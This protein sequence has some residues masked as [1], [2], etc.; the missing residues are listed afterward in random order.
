MGVVEMPKVVSLQELVRKLDGE[1]DRV[2]LFEKVCRNEDAQLDTNLSLASMVPTR[3]NRPTSPRKSSALI[4]CVQSAL[5]TTLTSTAA[6]VVTPRFAAYSTPRVKNRSSWARIPRILRSSASAERGIRSVLRPEG[7]PIEPVAPPIWRC[8]WEQ[9]VKESVMTKVADVEARGRWV[10]ATVD[11]SRGLRMVNDGWA[12]VK[13]EFWQHESS[14][15]L[16]LQESVRVR[17]GGIHL[18]SESTK[19]RDLSA[20]MGLSGEGESLAEQRKRDVT[21]MRGRR[22]ERR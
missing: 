7:S 13:Q 14:W 19:P 22:R 18:V 6:V 5:F 9:T 2:W 17:S 3:A 21:G 1:R 10:D 16:E 20:A 15:S 12:E 8:L 4:F 11:C